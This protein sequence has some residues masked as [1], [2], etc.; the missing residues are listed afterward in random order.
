MMERDI[1]EK[2]QG[3]GMGDGERKIHSQPPGEG[4]GS[5]WAVDWA[6]VGT[7]PKEGIRVA[8]PVLPS[9]PAPV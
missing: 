5:G 4:K 7:E 6:E 8:F 2:Q 3:E 1:W 9:W